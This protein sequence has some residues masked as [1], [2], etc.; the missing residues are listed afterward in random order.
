MITVVLSGT[1][2]YRPL[3]TPSIQLSRA[4]FGLQGSD[5][6]PDRVSLLNISCA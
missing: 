2:T 4:F 1:Q 6:V 3:T 5:Q